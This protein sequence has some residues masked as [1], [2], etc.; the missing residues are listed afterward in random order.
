MYRYVH[1][2]CVC[3]C[4][5][6]SNQNIGLSTSA[7]GV[8]KSLHNYHPTLKDWS[9]AVGSGSLETGL[10][11]TYI[12]R[13]FP[14]LSPFSFHSPSVCRPHMIYTEGLLWSDRAIMSMLMSHGL[15]N[16]S[17]DCLW[18]L[19]EWMGGVMGGSS[20]QFQSRMTQTSVR[21]LLEKCVYVC[22]SMPAV[23]E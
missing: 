8:I 17:L 21:T 22:V 16:G 7:E 13:H 15:I 5:A 1:F 12:E 4:L 10:A 11:Q 6:L 23:S 14:L 3:V 18:V 19:R 20:H 2:Q 9:T